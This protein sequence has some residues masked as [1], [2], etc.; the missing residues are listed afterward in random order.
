VASLGRDLQHLSGDLYPAL[1]DHFGLAVACAN[2]ARN[3]PVSIAF[4]SITSTA[5][6]PPA[7]PGTYRLTLYRIAEEALS[8]VARHARANGAG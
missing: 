3:S 4:R 5:G 1:L 2:T 8:N 7:F 6:S